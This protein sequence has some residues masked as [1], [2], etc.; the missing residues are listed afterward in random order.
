MKKKIVAL[1]AAIAAVLGFGFATGTAMADPYGQPGVVE[2]NSV[3]FTF[4]GLTPNGEVT[5]TADDAVVSDI[6]PVI[7]RKFNADKNGTLTVKF[8]L[9]DGV[10]A[11][12]VVKATAE[13]K[14]T[15][16]TV[17]L[18]ATV[19]STGAGNKVPQTGASVAPY[20]VAVVLL[21]AAGC[22]VF[23]ARKAGAR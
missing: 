9:K 15:G 16:K 6:V 2:G 1:L 4:Q 11:G 8:I 14:A 19:P 3:S 18:E 22:A 12:T 7:S 20:A 21:A 17:T 13:D 23:T 10:A 5:V